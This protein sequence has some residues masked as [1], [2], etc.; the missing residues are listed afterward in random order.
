MSGRDPAEVER[1][2]AGFAAARVDAESIFTASV[3]RPFLTC[4]SEPAGTDLDTQRARL[5]E[6]EACVS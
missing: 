2:I 6:E 1:V 3:F 5:R 4:R